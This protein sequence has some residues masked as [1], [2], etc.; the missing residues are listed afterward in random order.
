MWQYPDW[1]K[2]SKAA[3]DKVRKEKVT[4]AVEQ[5]HEVCIKD[6]VAGQGENTES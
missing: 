1:I 3:L 4:V 6:L 5:T 2:R